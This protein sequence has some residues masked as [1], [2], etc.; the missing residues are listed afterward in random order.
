M[1]IH[2]VGMFLHTR[3]FGI[4]LLVILF[5]V[6]LV[7]FALT[8]EEIQAQIQSYREQIRVLQ[9]QLDELRQ[10][11]HA[12]STPLFPRWR[13]ICPLLTHDVPFW[14]TSDVVRAI[15]EA[16]AE[17]QTVYPG[18]LATGY[19]GPLTQSALQRLVDRLTAQGFATT[20]LPFDERARVGPWLRKLLL[21]YWCSNAPP[22][23]FP[24]D[25][26]CPAVA[27]TT[28]REPCAGTWERL[29]GWRSCHVGWRCIP[30]LPA[31]N[32]QPTISS[33]AGPT[34][35]TVRESGTWTIQASDPE[36]DALSYRLVWGDEGVEERLLH[37]AELDAGAFVQS[38][39]F[40][41]T[42]TKPGLYLIR[43][44]ARDSAG[45]TAHA[46]AYVKVAP[47]A[48]EGAVHD[49][50]DAPVIGGIPG[51]LP[52]DDRLRKRICPFL[53]KFERVLTEGMEGDDVRNLQELLRAEGFFNVVPTGYFG[54][55]THN[56]LLQWQKLIPAITYPNT[57]DS[58]LTIEQI[59][60]WGKLI[61]A[62]YPNPRAG[63]GLAQLQLPWPKNHVC[64][65]GLCPGVFDRATYDEVLRHVKAWCGAYATTTPTTGASCTTP[66]GTTLFH[67][68]SVNAYQ[69]L[70]LQTYP[71]Q[72]RCALEVR[73]C[74]N[75]TL[76]GSY[77]LASC[78]GQ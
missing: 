31:T 58:T 32:Q 53:A 44:A 59:K 56:A 77:T 65:I 28:P 25:L 49:F 18:G 30:T 72:Q 24:P 51:Q 50:D 60:Q 61:P 14:S 21:R 8:T 69:L 38:T 52:D 64:G 48:Q 16:L 45:N 7:S 29:S 13:R 1:V 46:I 33:F 36:G 35:L 27:T 9:Q 78:V 47:V 63:L 3:A 74:T 10:P 66:W 71:V 62:T 6:P 4:W 20:T 55:L 2:T 12:T 73:S 43:V 17:D 68:Q 75:G 39:T 37:I 76:S 40:T 54:P 15:Q 34:A 67:G 11:Q 22:P 19:F 23:I 41:H 5:A 26:T 57:R 42:Y 70:E